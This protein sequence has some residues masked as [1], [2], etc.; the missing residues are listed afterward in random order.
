MS[1]HFR[2]GR[3]LLAAALERAPQEPTEARAS[4]L[5]GAGLLAAEQ[6]DGESRRLLED[7]LADARAAGSTRMEANALTLLSYH[8]FG[9]EE[10]I[11]LGEE[12]ITSALTSGDR[13]LLGLVT[14]NHG[15]L[16]A[17]FGEIEKATELT[18]DAYRLSRGVGDFSLSP[19]GSRTSRNSPCG[20]GTPPPPAAGWRSRSSSPGSSTTPAEPVLRW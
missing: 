10:Q 6:G 7:G 14:G 4:A 18:D 5:V 13:W 17:V 1:G 3:E 16:M 8:Q 15:D 19:S 2:E 20:T 11:R 12:A 9:R